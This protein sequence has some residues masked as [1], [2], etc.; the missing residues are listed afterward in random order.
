[1]YLNAHTGNMRFGKMMLYAGAVMSL[2]IGAAFATGQEVLMYFVAWGTEMFP[3]IAIILVIIIWVSLSFAIAGSRRHFQKNEEIFE[4]FCGRYFGKVY[5]YFT[6]IF[7]YACYLFMIGGVGST[8]KEQFGL[9]GVIG[10]VGLSAAVV[11]TVSLGL[12]RITDILGFLG[13]VLLAVILIISAATLLLNI[14]QLIPNFEAIQAYGPRH[15]GMERSIAPNALM[16]ALN[17]MGTVVIW[18]ITFITMMAVQCERKIEIKA[19]SVTGSVLFMLSLLVVAFAMISV[20]PLVGASDVPSVVMAGNLWK[21]LASIF[22]VIVVGGSFTTAVPLLWTP[23]S[24][25]AGDGSKKAKLLSGIL[26]MA[27][28]VIALLVPYK[29][30][31]NYIMNIGGMLAYVMYGFILWTDI[32]MFCEFR[33]EKATGTGSDSINE[34]TK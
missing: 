24:R 21:P 11:L 27:G 25:F 23:V 22:A 30:L 8:L 20:I 17:Y 15:F 32:R 10:I 19:G 33:K 18:F 7:S 12:Q 31:M 6:V 4:Y 1:M 2:L 3:V 5:D 29:S 26:G 34:N 28:I 14:E 16:N 13:S 9:P